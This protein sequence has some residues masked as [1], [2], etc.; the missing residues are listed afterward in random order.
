MFITYVGAWKKMWND[1][2]Q[3]TDTGYL[4]KGGDKEGKG[5]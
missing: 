3:G 5:K 2:T 4:E 1:T